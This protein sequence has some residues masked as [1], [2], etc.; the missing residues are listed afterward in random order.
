MSTAA[1]LSRARA[2]AAHLMGDGGDRS[3]WHLPS[4]S[5]PQTS[6]ARYS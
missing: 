2:V 4:A 1:S 3:S 5:G 6:S